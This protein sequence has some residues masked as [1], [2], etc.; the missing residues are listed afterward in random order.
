MVWSTVAAANT[1]RARAPPAPRAPYPRARVP[2][3]AP[4]EG[5]RCLRTLAWVTAADAAAARGDRHTCTCQQQR[6]HG[7]D[8]TRACAGSSGAT[9]TP[10]T[11]AWHPR[12][13]HRRVWQVR[14]GGR[15]A[16]QLP[17][18][19]HCV[20]ALVTAAQ[21]ITLLAHTTPPTSVC[22]EGGDRCVQWQVLLQAGP[23]ACMGQ[24]VRTRARTCIRD[25][26]PPRPAYM[27]ARTHVPVAQRCRP[28]GLPLTKMPSAPSATHRATC[29]G[30]AGGRC[31]ARRPRVQT[32]AWRASTSSL[33][34]TATAAGFVFGLAVC[35]PAWHA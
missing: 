20:A 10:A 34:G 3:T 21:A 6:Q 11:R 22:Q 26:T 23:A 5:A 31:A 16:W 32:A 30:S 19:T 13:P 28:R 24:P 17:S 33:A 8:A 12:P 1:G 14:R 29:R 35:K 15:H 18:K 2:T 9:T 7:A 4:R 27:H 25:G